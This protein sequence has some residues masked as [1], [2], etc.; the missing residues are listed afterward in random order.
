M[1]A[2]GYAYPGCVRSCPN[3]VLQLVGPLGVSKQ[4]YVVPTGRVL[5]S[6]G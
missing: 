2:D 5:V 3:I 6:T 4:R 1:G